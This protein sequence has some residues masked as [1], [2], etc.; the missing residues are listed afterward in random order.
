MRRSA[1]S[2][3]ASSASPITARIRASRA[4][5]GATLLGLSTG[6]ARRRGCLSHEGAGIVDAG[7]PMLGI[8][9]L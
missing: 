6:R 5:I 8:V 4:P 1:A 2:T 9:R 7:G 3:R